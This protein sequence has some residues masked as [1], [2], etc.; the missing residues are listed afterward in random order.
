MDLPSPRRSRFPLAHGLPGS[1][2]RAAAGPRPLFFAAA[3]ALTA[4]FVA[5][6][7]D[8]WA[9]DRVWAI[10]SLVG[11]EGRMTY[12][13]AGMGWPVVVGLALVRRGLRRGEPRDLGAGCALLQAII[14]VGGIT[15]FLK[16]ATGRPPPHEGID[17]RDFRWLAFDQKSLRVMWPSGHTSENVAAAAALHA[18][19]GRTRGV[20]LAWIAA[21]LVVASMLVGG[22]HWLSD[23]A[24]GALVA[25]PFGRAIGTALRAWAGEG[26]LQSAESS[27]PSSRSG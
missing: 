20:V 24:A 5:S 16:L 25:Y 11:F 23:L 18:F 2:S 13:Y 8:G 12:F 4:V 17:P 3:V 10:P 19:H 15:L 14:V 7:L 6:G 9:R 1:L 27:V 26:Q 21:A 22:F